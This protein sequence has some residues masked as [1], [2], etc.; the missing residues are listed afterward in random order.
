MSTKF[1]GGRE[2]P[3]G[4]GN[5]LCGLLLSDISR[6][7]FAVLRQYL[8]IMARSTSV[9]RDFR[10]VALGP[11][12]WLGVLTCASAV[13]VGWIG[14]ASSVPIGWILFGTALLVAASAF[15][16]HAIASST[17]RHI[18]V[19]VLH[20]AACL[21]AV[22][23]IVAGSY[24]TWFQPSEETR[25]TFGFL[26]RTDVNKIETQC[27]QPSGYPGG[28]PLALAKSNRALAPMCGGQSYP[29]ECVRVL[30]SGQRWFR[31]S[32]NGYWSGYW[33]SGDLIWPEPGVSVAEIPPCR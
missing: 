22:F 1:S 3:T 20:I 2:R 25:T 18:K 10:R 28:P 26:L 9:P 17:P 33:M 12:V 13:V 15:W 19:R 24:I 5:H 23:I 30:D 16:G 7:Y 8:R 4:Q 27:Q 31:F 11:E 14:L 6:L 29:F 32:S 21:L